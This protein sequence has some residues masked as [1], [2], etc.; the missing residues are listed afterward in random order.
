[1]ANIDPK[2]K[3]YSG[4]E[5]MAVFKHS[6]Q[7]V[8]PNRNAGKITSEV[9]SKQQR[10][11]AGF[12]QVAGI[13]DHKPSNPATTANQA[14]IRELKSVIAKQRQQLDDK[15]KECCELES[16][17]TKLKEQ[18]DHLKEQLKVSRKNEAQCQKQVESLIA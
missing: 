13:Y 8:N 7:T 11:E 3:V 17:N 16:A 9:V 6:E 4:A 5:L 18:I 10:I 2:K 1:M 12:R 14:E 15:S